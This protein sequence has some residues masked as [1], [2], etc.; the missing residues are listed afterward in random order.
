MPDSRTAL[1]TL[2][3]LGS[4]PLVALAHE[5]PEGTAKSHANSAHAHAAATAATIK[6]EVLPNEQHAAG[7]SAPSVI[8]LTAPDGTPVTPDQLEVAHTE[9]IHLLIIDESLG[10]YH[11]EHPTPTDKP[12]EYKFS[13]QPRNGGRYAVFADLLPKATGRQ[14][15]ARTEVHVQGAPRPLDQSAAQAAS[16]DGYKFDLSMDGGSAFRVG[17]AKLVKVK[18][19]APDGK[20]ATHLEPVM[21]AFAHGVGFPSDRSGVVHVHPMGKEPTKDSERGGPELMF[22]IVPEHAGYMKFYVQ[23]QVGGEQKFAGFGFHV[24]EASPRVATASGN[25]SSLAPEQKQFLEH[26]E[27]IRS[28]LAADDFANAKQAAHIL[29]ESK[30]GEAALAAEIAKASSIKAAREAFKKLS[31][32]ATKIAANQQGYFV[33]NCPMTEN[34]R[35]VQTTDKVANPYFGAS[36]LKCGSVAN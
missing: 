25:S 8:R 29:A 5:K 34:G 30:N 17:E 28:A 11:H 20:P 24:D 21:G 31:A 32:S 19:T 26:Y 18:V 33:M 6:V 36:M 14:E 15:Y 3:A 1:I 13:F 4:M 2:I 16:V 23:V 22:H 27:M 10:D 35:W 9:K 12:G 7:Q